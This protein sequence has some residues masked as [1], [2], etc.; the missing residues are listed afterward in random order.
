MATGTIQQQQLQ[1]FFEILKESKLFS[2]LE[3]L[4][5][6]PT[7]NHFLSIQ[8]GNQDAKKVSI[9]FVRG[10]L[11]SYNAATQIPL[12]GN[13]TA[14]EGDSY[15]VSVGGTVDFGSGNV[16]LQA[17]DVIEFRA[18]QWRKKSK[19]KNF[20][21]EQGT[22]SATWI[23]NHYMGKY[24]SVSVIDSSGSE[25]EGEVTYNNIDTLTIEFNGG[26]SGTATLN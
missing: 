16:S 25:V 17:E 22:P 5:Q 15:F 12:I 7:L 24:P 9:P 4:Q 11:G 1:R 3:E 13:T 14:I 2:E 10:V 6:S 26:F 21:Y 20:V 8:Q 23:I 18:G 19:D